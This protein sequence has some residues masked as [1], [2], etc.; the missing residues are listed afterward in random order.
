MVDTTQIYVL[1]QFDSTRRHKLD[2]FYRQW[3]A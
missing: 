3:L 2:A 1:L